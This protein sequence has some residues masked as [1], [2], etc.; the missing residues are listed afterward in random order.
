MLI[1]QI[2]TVIRAFILEV[3]SQVTLKVSVLNCSFAH[4][5]L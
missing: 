4:Y 5:L 3:V 1:M 2:I